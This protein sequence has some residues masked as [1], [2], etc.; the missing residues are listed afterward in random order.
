MLED[1]YTDACP[2]EAG[3]DGPRFTDAELAAIGSPV[4]FAGINVYRPSV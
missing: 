1:R 3:R 4:D 2:A